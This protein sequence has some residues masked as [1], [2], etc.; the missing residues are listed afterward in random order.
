MK[1]TVGYSKDN[2]RRSVKG[3][4]PHIKPD[5]FKWDPKRPEDEENKHILTRIKNLHQRGHKAT[6]CEWFSKYASN[7]SCCLYSN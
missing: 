7:L 2:Y 5:N 4:I 1:A 3:D 6:S